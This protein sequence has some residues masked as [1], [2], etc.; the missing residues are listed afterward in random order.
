MT[1]RCFPKLTQPGWADDP[2]VIQGRC[3][4]LAVHNSILWKIRSRWLGTEKYASY[5]ANTE[6][7]TVPLD[8]SIVI[9]EQPQV[10]AMRFPARHSTFVTRS[11]PAKLMVQTSAPSAEMRKRFPCWCVFDA[12]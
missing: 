3:D 7:N 9:M 5:F 4:D 11:L 8:L 12:S 10:H 6:S 1:R 2:G